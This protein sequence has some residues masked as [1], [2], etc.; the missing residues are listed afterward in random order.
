MRG[1]HGDHQVNRALTEGHLPPVHFFE[2][3]VIDVTTV[4][5]GR[6]HHLPTV[7][8]AQYR[9]TRLAL[10]H[11]NRYPA[12]PTTDIQGHTILDGKR[13]RDSAI[14]GL[15]IPTWADLVEAI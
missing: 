6:S 2:P 3:Q 10:R 1:L 15:V 5:L 9:Q 4:A 7:V 11:T 8:D 14:R 12:W 13:F